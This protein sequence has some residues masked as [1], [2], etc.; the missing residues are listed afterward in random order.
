MELSKKEHEREDKR[1]TERNEIYGFKKE[2]IREVLRKVKLE[3]QEFKLLGVL[4]FVL[5]LNTGE[6]LPVEIKYTDYPSPSLRWRKQL[7]AYAL[8]LE[9]TFKVTIKRAI[10]YFSMQNTHE[11]IEISP[12]D[13]NLIKEDIKKMRELIRNESI[14]KKVDESKCSYCEMKKFCE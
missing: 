1:R 12:Q 2:D 6:M 10:L 3:N 4:D 5:V 13:K 8:L 7:F 9:S 14:P 11:I